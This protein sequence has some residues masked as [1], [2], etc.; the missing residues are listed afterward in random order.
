MEIILVDIIIIAVFL[1]TVGISTHRG[2]VKSAIGVAVILCSFVAAKMFGG[3]IGEWID[4]VFMFD[5]INGFV[6]TFL[7]STLGELSESIDAASLIERVP[8]TIKNAPELAGADVS[9]LNDYI[10]SVGVI[11]EANI[12]EVSAKMATPISAFI[13]EVIGYLSVFIVGIIVFKMIGSLVV[14]IFKLPLLRTLDKILGFLVGT[15]TGFLLAWGFAVVFRAVMGL[16][17]ISHPELLPFASSDGSYVY[18]FF[19]NFTI[20]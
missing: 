8:E 11:T 2:F 18:D 6:A 14:G 19:V 20:N 13:S 15:F 3:V 1:I 12:K 5:T 17:A 10:S 16:L 9:S 4:G 7:R